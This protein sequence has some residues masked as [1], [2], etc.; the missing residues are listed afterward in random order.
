MLTG[1]DRVWYVRETLRAAFPPSTPIGRRLLVVLYTGYFDESGTH[2][3][4]EVVAVA[5]FVA[6]TSNWEQF[7]EDW[8]AIL[9][10]CSL[11]YFHMSEFENMQG[12]YTSWTDTEGKDCL[13]R[14]LDTIHEHVIQ[15]VAFIIPKMSFDLLMSAKAKRICG[16]AYGLAALE[17]WRK[18]ADTARD[19]RLDGVLNCIME[20]GA[21][22]RHALEEIH[23]AGSEDAAWQNEN[24]I[25][26]LA[27]Q[28]KRVFLP[29]QAADILAYELYKQ[30]LRQFGQE[31]RRGRY[32]LRQLARSPRQWHYLDDDELRQ[33]SQYLTEHPAF[34]DFS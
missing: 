9:N 22:G 24:P 32:P 15:S 6:N 23:A 33:V 8:Q 25:L 11:E 34:G 13:N 18:L 12:P 2:D 30:G 17:C 28:D 20:S 31:T 7:S 21:R 3:G 4:S 27:F 5:G 29:L 26:S 19:P 14:L 1:V 10:D 16:D